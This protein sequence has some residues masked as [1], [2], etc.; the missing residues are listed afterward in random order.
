MHVKVP[1]AVIHLHVRILLIQIFFLALGA[2]D[3]FL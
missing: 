2:L 1:V 3:D